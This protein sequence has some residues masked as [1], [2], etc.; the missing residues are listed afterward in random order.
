MTRSERESKVTEYEGRDPRENRGGAKRGNGSGDGE[1]SLNLL[2][3]KGTGKKEKHYIRV[4]ESDLH[5]GKRRWMKNERKGRREVRGEGGIARGNEVE[6]RIVRDEQDGYGKNKE[7]GYKE[8]GNI[9]GEHGDSEE[10]G[11]SSITPLPQ[12]TYDDPSGSAPTPHLWFQRN[13]TSIQLRRRYFG[14]RTMGGTL[15]IHSHAPKLP[16]TIWIQESLR[17]HVFGELTWVSNRFQMTTNLRE[18][19]RICDCDYKR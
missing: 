19:M 12:P 8:I 9:E 16:P 18:K 13:F 10:V 3:E 6:V 5:G 15:A 4:E 11:C 17:P 1:A 2:A 7:R 14:S